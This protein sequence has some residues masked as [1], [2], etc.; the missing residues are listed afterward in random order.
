MRQ[1]AVDAQ[2]ELKL[3]RL[4]HCRFRTVQMR[5]YLAPRRGFLGWQ[6]NV[7]GVPVEELSLRG[8]VPSAER[9]GVALAFEYIQWLLAERQISVRTEGLVIRS[10]MAAAKHVHHDK[11]QVR[12]RAVEPL[13]NPPLAGHKDLCGRSSMSAALLPQ[14]CCFWCMQML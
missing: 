1:H 13:D 6:H 8:A 10:I 7:R 12:A 2:V 5:L 11:S 4:Q 9:D 3:R 14:L